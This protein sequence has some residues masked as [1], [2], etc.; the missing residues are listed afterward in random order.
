V[1]PS[2]INF[3]TVT[4][5]SITTKTVTVSNTGTRL[6]PSARL[7]FRSCKAGNSDEFVAVNLCPSSLAAGKSC[8]ITVAFVAGAY[9][10]PQTATLEIMDNAPGSPQ[11]VTL[12]AT[13]LEPQTITFTT[14]PPAS[15]AYNSSF[16]VA[17]TGA[18]AGSR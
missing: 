16:T 7:S 3:G 18:R 17:A 1:S 9:Y 5:G 8:T 6:P 4:L 15:A 13:V 10:T 2:S 12:S 11:M 14:N